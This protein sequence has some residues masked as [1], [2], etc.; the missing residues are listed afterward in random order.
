VPNGAGA[1]L[2]PPSLHD[3]RVPELLALLDPDAAFP[4]PELASDAGALA[5]LQRLGLRTAAGARAVGARA[6][7]G[8]SRRH[9]RGREPAA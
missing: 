7:G 5:A 6:L 8:A 4:A 3:P 9:S 2:A 1:L